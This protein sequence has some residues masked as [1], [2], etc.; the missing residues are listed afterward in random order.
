LNTHYG[1]LE[2]D[3]P[4]VK[5][6]SGRI[7]IR[8]NLLLSMDKPAAG[9]STTVSMEHG[10]IKLDC[11][12]NEIGLFDL[13]LF[14]DRRHTV[15][16]SINVPISSSF[17]TRS[18]KDPWAMARCFSQLMNRHRNYSRDIKPNRWPRT[19]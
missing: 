6:V 15:G 17:L 16:W 7:E 1:L 9:V 11:C 14:V 18:D 3:P 2:I 19:E 4:Q 13:D 10:A 5:I 8:I 12:G